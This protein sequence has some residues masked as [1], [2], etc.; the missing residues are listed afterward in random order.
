MLSIYRSLNII[1]KF[2][3]EFYKLLYIICINF[4][5]VVLVADFNIHVNN[6]KDRY[7]NEDILII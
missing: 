5:C 7:A 4:D 6:A 2:F 3:D 1:K